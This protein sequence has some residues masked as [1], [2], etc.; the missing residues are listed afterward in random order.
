MGLNAL[1]DKV[2][3][4]GRAIVGRAITASRQHAIGP[5]PPE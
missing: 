4:E 3:L 5:L 1:A 2:Q